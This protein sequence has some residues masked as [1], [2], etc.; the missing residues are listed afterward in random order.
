[1]ERTTLVDGR[2]ILAEE[3][4]GLE[5]ALLGSTY[6]RRPHLFESKGIWYVECQ[7][8]EGTQEHAWSPSGH[9]ADPDGGHYSCGPCCGTGRFK[10]EMP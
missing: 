3:C 1:M 10:I 2:R 9:G 8:C 6:T 5:L 7:C 4:L